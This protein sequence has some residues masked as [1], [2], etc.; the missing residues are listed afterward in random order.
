MHLAAVAVAF[1][2]YRH[3][4]SNNGIQTE[5]PLDQCGCVKWK[6]P[7]LWRKRHKQFNLAL[8]CPASQTTNWRSL[9][10]PCCMAR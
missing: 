10:K 2:T 9:P 3:P 5:G 8:L 7:V 4:G 1:W 6:Q